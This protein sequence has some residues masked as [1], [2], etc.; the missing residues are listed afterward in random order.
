MHH[1]RYEQDG[2]APH[3]AA[4]CGDGESGQP[5]C[6]HHGAAGGDPRGGGAQG[7]SGGRTSLP[8]HRQWC[9][10]K[11]CPLFCCLPRCRIFWILL[12]LLISV[13]A[14]V[15]MVIDLKFNT[16][17]GSV[18]SRYQSQQGL[19][20]SVCSIEKYTVTDFES[21]ICDEEPD[22][23]DCVNVARNYGCMQ[24]FVK[25][26]DYYTSAIV[27]NEAQLFRSDWEYALVKKGK[28]VRTRWGG[29]TVWPRGSRPVCGN[30]T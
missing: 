10:N 2:H 9:V 23:A 1:P 16:T 7:S 27:T 6:Q 21:C 30:L 22:V 19:I 5:F 18:L 13:G 14:I 20:T 15:V 8:P 11:G 12:L 24:I 29:S 17:Y 26:Y 28:M 4:C 25:A 3:G